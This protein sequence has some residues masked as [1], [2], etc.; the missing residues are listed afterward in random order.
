MPSG[1]SV[2]PSR[3]IRP[4]FP[5][6][7]SMAMSQLT[8]PAKPGPNPIARRPSRRKSG[9]A[10]YFCIRASIRTSMARTTIRS[11]S[12]S[13]VMVTPAACA[14]PA[15]IST[16][17]S[18]RFAA[19]PS[20]VDVIVEQGVVEGHLPPDHRGQRIVRQHEP[21]T[22][23]MKPHGNRRG[24]FVGA[25]NHGESKRMVG[26]HFRAAPYWLPLRQS[27][28]RAVWNAS[29]MPEES[30][31]VVRAWAN[32]VVSATERNRHVGNLTLG[33]ARDTTNGRSPTAAP[34]CNGPD[35]DLD[36][37]QVLSQVGLDLA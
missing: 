14:R 12:P 2:Q 24:D 4:A 28:S 23:A 8:P 17:L 32:R 1:W 16:V 22:L 34:R 15:R 33:G 7:V 6:R 35:N 20:T 25:E 13:S 9:V 19:M 5:G 36:G 29:K 31:F 30:R 27:K 10:R 18:A 11:S 37:F 3:T 21:E 26:P